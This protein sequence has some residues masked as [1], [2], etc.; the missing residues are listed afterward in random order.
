VQ[1]TAY[2]LYDITNNNNFYNLQKDSLEQYPIPDTQ[3]TARK[4]Y[5][6]KVPE[7]FG[8]HA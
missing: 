7:Y 3:L 8:G 1:D 4:E 2:K 5:K 6:K